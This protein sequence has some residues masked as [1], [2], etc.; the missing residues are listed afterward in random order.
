M[1]LFDKEKPSYR[2]SKEHLNN[3]LQV[4]EAAGGHFGRQV[5]KSIVHR[6]GT[7]LIHEI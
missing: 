7:E 6:S 4:D 3:L 5:L 1:A 2:G